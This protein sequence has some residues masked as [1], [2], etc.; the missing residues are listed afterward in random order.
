GERALNDHFE[1]IGVRARAK[2]EGQG[3]RVRYAPPDPAPLVSIIVPTRNAHEL[4]RTCLTSVLRR[5]DYPDFEILLVDNGSDD[6]EA[7]RT[8]EALARGEPRVRV[9]RDDREFNFSALNNAAARE[10]RGEFLVLMNNDIEV[11][12]RDWLTEMLG[13]GA[14]PG[15]GAV[16]ARLWYPNRTLQHGGVF[17]SPVFV[18]GHA[19]RRLPRGLRG[20]DHRAALYQDVSAVT[21]ASLLVAKGTY[22]RFGGLDETAMKI[23]FND[24]DFCLR[25]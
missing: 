12:S 15:V 25:L 4:V 6:P 9:L 19:H 2:H 21:G 20:Y 13:L 24:I 8:F 5:T 16:G 10:A 18:A 11:L 14:Q 22:E 3:Y 7:V 17:L 1:R 23:A